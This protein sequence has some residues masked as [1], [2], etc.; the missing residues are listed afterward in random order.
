[1]EDCHQA[2]GG[3]CTKIPG[4]RKALGGGE[5]VVSIRRGL[6]DALLGTTTL[7]VLDERPVQSTLCRR[8][9]NLLYQKPDRTLVYGAP[10]T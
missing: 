10:P 6:A 1:M 8:K 3:L 7:S 9:E 2:I 5:G 4:R